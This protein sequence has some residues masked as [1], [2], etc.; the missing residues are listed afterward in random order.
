MK[1]SWSCSSWSWSKRQ[2]WTHLRWKSSRTVCLD[3]TRHSVIS[4]EKILLIQSI[5]LK[6]KLESNWNPKIRK[7]LQVSGKES[8]KKLS[9]PRASPL[10]QIRVKKCC[11]RAYCPNYSIKSSS[12]TRAT[13]TTTTGR[14]RCE[15]PTTSSTCLNCPRRLAKTCPLSTLTQWASSGAFLM[16][17]TP[18]PR[19]LE[20]CSCPL[21][22]SSRLRTSGMQT[23]S[24]M[25]WLALNDHRWRPWSTM[26]CSATT[27]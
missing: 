9:Y 15:I 16:A 18:T 11:L 2:P 23:L 24:S 17:S 3:N 25:Q 7:R 27:R 26:K 8:D 19:V 21:A 20:L 6:K 22:P 14:K 12:G 13:I 1:S 4:S 10:A 5:S